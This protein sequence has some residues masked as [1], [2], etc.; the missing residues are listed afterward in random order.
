V[1][2]IQA[3]SFETGPR[4]L[5]NDNDVMNMVNASKK[6]DRSLS[7]KILETKSIVYPKFT[8]RSLTQTVII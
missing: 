1:Y 7:L 6:M 3:L 4:T 5:E 8:N 2:R